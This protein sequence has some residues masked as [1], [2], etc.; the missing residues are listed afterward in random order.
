MAHRLRA[1]RW[2]NVNPALVQCDYWYPSKREILIQ[3]CF[4]VGPASG[5]AL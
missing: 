2:H 5:P 3:R 1:R 4:N